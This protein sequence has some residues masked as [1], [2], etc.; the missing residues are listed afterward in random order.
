[1]LGSPGADLGRRAQAIYLPLSLHT[2]RQ[3][4]NPLLGFD[5]CLGV[6][7]EKMGQVEGRQ[8]SIKG[9]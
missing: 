8:Q 4:L 1:M 5:G 9:R 2:P 3:A 6:Q 7:A